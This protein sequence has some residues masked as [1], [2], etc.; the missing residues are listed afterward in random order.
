MT[1]ELKWSKVTQQKVNEYKAFI[2]LFF[3]FNELGKLSF[4][5]LVL[6]NTKLKHR[7]F[8]GSY[9]LGFYK[10]FY[11]L[12]IHGFGKRY[13]PSNDLYVFLDQRQTGYRLDDLRTVL[14]NGMKKRYKIDRRPFRLV[15][16]AD[17]KKIAAVQIADIILGAI[18]YRKNSW[19]LQPGAKQAKIDLS[20]YVLRRAKVKDSVPDTPFGQTRFT[21][22]NFRLR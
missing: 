15:E 20:A 2:D 22:W 12:L 4:H 17:S 21:V 1:K 9:E 16:F 6:D 5:C 11:Q 14:N 10:F 3:K 18:G 19:Y 13:G 8:S 7:Q